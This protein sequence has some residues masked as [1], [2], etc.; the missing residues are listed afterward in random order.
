MP[1][2]QATNHNFTGPG[3]PVL[4]MKE[5]AVSPSLVM[6]QNVPLCAVFPTHALFEIQAIHEYTQ[7]GTKHLSILKS[8]SYSKAI[9]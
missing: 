5:K 6:P 8:M 9:L 1:N 4:V 3:D 2:Q 7:K